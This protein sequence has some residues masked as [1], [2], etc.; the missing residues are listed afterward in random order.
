MTPGSSTPDPENFRALV[1]GMEGAASTPLSFSAWVAPEGYLQLDDVV[2][3]QTTLPDGEVVDTYGVVDELRATQEGVALTSDVSLSTE[4]ILPTQ[5]S[6]AAHVS[7]TRIEPDSPASRSQLLEGDIIIAF[8]GKAVTSTH[9][10][11]KELTSHNI[12]A[13]IDIS[14][15]RHT[16]LLN[17]SIAPVKK[18]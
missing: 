14:V 1:L 3:V 13:M 8:H 18:L 4:G 12:L 16:E 2:H 9:E 11:F 6:V 15:I 17:F 7:V 10:L 5:S